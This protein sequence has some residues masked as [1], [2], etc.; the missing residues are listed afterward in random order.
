VSF[1][2]FC[3]LNCFSIIRKGTIYPLSDTTIH[4]SNESLAPTWKILGVS[5]I[6][7]FIVLSKERQ[8]LSS[9]KPIFMYII[10]ELTNIVCTYFGKLLRHA[11]I[12]GKLCRS[13]CYCPVFCL[14][15][16]CVCFTTIAATCQHQKTVIRTLR[17]PELTGL[18]VGYAI[19]PKICF[20]IKLS[21]D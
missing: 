14:K 13:F 9:T 8:K 15:Y 4:T 1:K 5:L 12:N 10:I 2:L 18:D 20:N 3:G 7:N 6:Q 19:M 11:E 16:H 17:M 21:L